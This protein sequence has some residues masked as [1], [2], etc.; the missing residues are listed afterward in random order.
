MRSSLRPHQVK[1]I[2]S[3]RSSLARGKRRPMLQAPTGFGKTILAAAIVDG[4]L[5]KNNRVLFTVPSISLI[6]QTVESFEREGIT[7]VGVIQADHPM[8][9]ASQP[10][11]VASVQTLQNRFIPDAEIV[12][13]DEAHRWFNFH[14]DWFKQPAWAHIPFVGLSATPW[15]KGLGKYYD[16]LIIAAT[17]QDLIDKGYLSKFEVFAPSHPDLTGIKTVAGDYHEGQLSEAMQEGAL[18]ADVV[19]TWLKLGRNEPTLCFGVDRAHAKALRAA[20][21]SVGVAVEY[22]DAT[23]PISE[24]EEIR[25]RFKTGET[26]IVCNVG[27]LTTGVDWDVRCLILARPTKSEILFTQIIGRALR[28]A[29]GK[30]VARI[31]DHSDTHLRLGMVT[32]IHKTTLCDG[33]QRRSSGA[34]D[35][36]TP[37]P[38]ECPKCSFLKPVRVHECPHCGFKPE[39]VSEVETLDGEL[40]AFAGASNG[41]KPE[42]TLAEKEDFYRQLLGYCHKRGLRQG[43]AD[44]K[45]KARFDHWPHKKHGLTPIQPRAEVYNWIKHCNIKFAKSKKR[46]AA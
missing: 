17:T 12:V 31:L 19:E 16:D 41:K 43:Y 35:A 30:D 3:L 2:Q 23:T 24:R 13:I 10:V 27:V 46:N 36:V 4:A 6:D 37:L 1:A 21:E 39:R 45:F 7:D 26:K 22:I 42:P 34:R 8:T 28:T 5:K 44:H 25:E 32:D 14:T 11:Q 33:A 18:V 38:K 29:E 40:F 9:D 20:F 15:T